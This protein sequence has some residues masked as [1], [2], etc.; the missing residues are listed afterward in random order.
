MIGNKVSKDTNRKKYYLCHFKMHSV[1]VAQTFTQKVLRLKKRVETARKRV[2]ELKRELKQTRPQQWGRL[3]E[4]TEKVFL[5]DIDFA[6]NATKKIMQ[7]EE[8]L[9]IVKITTEWDVTP[10]KEEK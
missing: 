6:H 7:E 3:L 8:D 2:L 5:D 4:Q 10:Q 1:I 9:G